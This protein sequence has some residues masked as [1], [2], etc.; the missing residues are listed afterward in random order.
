MNSRSL[1]RRRL[2]ADGHAG[3]TG[4]GDRKIVQALTEPG[5]WSAAQSADDLPEP[6]GLV[7]GEIDE[8]ERGAVGAN[9]QDERDDV[10]RRPVVGRREQALDG[11]ARRERRF[12]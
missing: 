9:A 1:S 12:R 3:Y 2:S 10:E 5:E 4:Q 8:R 6:A 7:P 11:H